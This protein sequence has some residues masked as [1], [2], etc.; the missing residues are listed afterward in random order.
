MKRIKLYFQVLLWIFVSL[1]VLDYN[2]YESLDEVNGIA[3]A[4]LE[5]LVYINVF[6]VNLHVLIPRVLKSK[7]KVSYVLSLALFLTLMYV[8]YYLIG[9]QIDLESEVP[10]DDSQLLGIS[11]FIILC[12]LYIFM[13]YLYW[14]LILFQQ[15]KQKNLALENEKLQAELLL[16]KSQ[17]YPH[18]LFNS[19][20]NIYSLSVVKHDNA[21]LMI[22]KLS[23]L[24][25]YI[26][27]DG[28][29][30]FV[31]LQKEITLLK[32]YIDLQFLKKLKGEKNIEIS[33]K[34]VDG[35]YTITPLL[36]INIIENC[37]KHSDIAYN[38][39]ALLI[40]RIE[41]KNNQLCFLTEN[42]FI[43]SHKNEAG[44]GL[45]NVQRQLDYYYPNKHTFNFEENGDVFM[46][47]LKIH[48]DL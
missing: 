14:Y 46:T 20:N 3:F 21:P 4:A 30:K 29:Q 40:I 33:I 5:I 10:L 7:G 43:L 32:N 8:P 12:A 27:Y 28:K 17:V 31:S 34:E 37:F 44:I 38:E 41:V 35:K 16:L 6:Y 15:E 1:S 42:S 23:D 25:R 26:I 22:E 11:S 47:K 9:S 2:I 18:F 48:L 13:S 45:R 19:L 39:N 36:L 24:L